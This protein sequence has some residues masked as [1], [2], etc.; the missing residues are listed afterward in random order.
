M[1]A[2]KITLMLMLLVLT[3]TALCGCKGGKDGN[4]SS[5]NNSTSSKYGGEIV[6]GIQQDIDSLDPHLA[7]AAGTKEV[8]FNIFEGLVKPDAN[9]NMVAAVASDYKISEDGLTYTFT[10]REGIKFHNGNLVTAEDIKYSIDRAAGLLNEGDAP[11]IANLSNVSKVEI[12]DEKT[13]NVILKS[14]N[15]EMICYMTAGIIPKDSDKQDTIVGTGPFKLESY[16]VQDSVVVV[17]NDNYWVPGVPYL[18]KVTFKIVSD[19]DSAMLFLKGGSID[20]YPYLTSDQAEELEGDLDIISGASNTVQA[21]FLNNAVEP[22]NNVDVRK[23]IC[24][25]MDEDAINAFVSGSRGEIVGS[26]MLP[27]LKDYYLDLSDAYKRDT[28]KAKELLK[29]AGYENGF[30]LEVIYPSNYQIHTDAATVIADQLK[31]VGIKVIL[32]PVDWNTWLTDVYKGRKY[33]ATVCAFATEMAPGYLLAKHVSDGSKNFLNYN[34][35]EY[36][37]CYAIAAGTTDKAIKAE[38]YKKM[39]QIMSDD[40]GCAFIQ[41][42]PSIVAKAKKVKGYTFYPVYVQDMSCIYISE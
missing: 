22:L 27:G 24:Y 13:V 18:D 17:K 23:A 10:L 42:A 7:A 20:L 8:L 1:K 21:L 39:Q 6:V 31:E 16:K 36:D 3:T 32:K 15:S 29:Q 26:M 30:E 40:A 35:P 19:T 5:D 25:A 28:K 14:A 34:N 11:L 4:T 33:Q 37:K 38:N 2:K 9:G 41:V 12:V